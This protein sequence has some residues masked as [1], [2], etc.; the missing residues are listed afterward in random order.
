MTLEL[1]DI[2]TGIAASLVTACGVIYAIYRYLAHQHAWRE[3]V[4]AVE[5]YL[6]GKVQKP[7]PGTQGMH[8]LRHLSRHVG[9]P[10]DDIMRICF[11]SPKIR[12][13]VTADERNKADKMLF[14]HISATDS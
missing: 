1:F 5:S 12:F 13:R 3:K 9:L 7:D 4:R 14:Q 10:E 6:E 2:W 11:A 8:S